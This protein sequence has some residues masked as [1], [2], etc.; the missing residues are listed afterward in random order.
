[1]DCVANGNP[2][3]ESDLLPHRICYEGKARQPHPCF[4]LAVTLLTD[5]FGLALR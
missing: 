2:G 4:V 3:I 5:H 1:M